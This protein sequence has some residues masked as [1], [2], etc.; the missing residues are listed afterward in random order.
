MPSLKLDKSQYAALVTT[1]KN[2]TGAIDPVAVPV[3]W[4]S[5]ERG[6]VIFHALKHDLRWGSYESLSAS[7]RSVLKLGYLML[8]QGVFGGATDYSANYEETETSVA[9]KVM[10]KLSSIA[11]TSNR[12]QASV[13]SSSSVSSFERKRL[14][15]KAQYEC[16]CKRWAAVRSILEEDIEN[17]LDQVMT[18]SVRDDSLRL[19]YGADRGM[20]LAFEK[21]D[22]DAYFYFRYEDDASFRHYFSS[23]RFV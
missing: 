9:R 6:R 20:R 11:S 7:K 10:D 23:R 15:G 16:D 13:G 3:N 19:H 22:V 18:R 5:D 2:S 12:G 17:F 21:G 1:M 8:L 14:L 4:K